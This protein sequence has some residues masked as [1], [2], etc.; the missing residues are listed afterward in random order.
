MSLSDEFSADELYEQVSE[1]CES[2]AEEFGM[3]GYDN[4]TAAD[5]WQ[6]V[7][8]S[9]KTLPAMHVLVNDILSLKI[10]KYMNW[11]MIN[12]YKNQG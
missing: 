6:C 10:T 11:V 5:V 4:I 8:S 12:M 1:L 3:L 9:Y 7:F 2:K